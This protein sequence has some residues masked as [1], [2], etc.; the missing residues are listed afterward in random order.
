MR[1]AFVLGWLLSLVTASQAT[2]VPDLYGIELPV[3]SKDAS[4]LS[5]N[6]RR[7]MNQVM[8]RLVRTED[9]GSAA[10]RAI[11]AKPEPYILQYEFI[12]GP[13]L[14]VDFDSNRLDGELRKRGI[15]VWGAQRPE[16]LVWLAVDD[17]G[18]QQVFDADAMPQLDS[19]LRMLADRTGLPVNVPLGDLADEQSLN[20]GDI[21]SGTA[22]RILTASE[23]YEPE[24]ILAGRLVHQP[25]GSWQSA[26]RL[27]QG[28]R[29]E[30]W[31]GE[32]PSL[33]EAAAVGLSGTYS[34]LAARYIPRTAQASNLELRVVG[35][36]SL[37]D[38]NRAAGYLGGLSPVAKVELLSVGADEAS[39]RLNVRG[40]RDLL[41]QTLAAGRRLKPVLDSESGASGATYRWTP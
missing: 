8:V 11:L 5:E 29:E 28:E 4:A 3:A 17:N 6:L 7:A 16:I 1:K 37:D 13:I 14:A 21:L 23:R 9:F 40:G 38:A 34:R 12:P 41:T 25:T 36:N 27:L 2:E 22:G 32:S 35:I 24:A 33:S 30:R 31:N 26:W 39:F 15:Q 18:R 20:A 19:A 10:V